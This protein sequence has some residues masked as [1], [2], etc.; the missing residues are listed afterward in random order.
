MRAVLA[1]LRQRSWSRQWPWTGQRSWTTGLACAVLAV[2]APAPATALT[3]GPGLPSATAGINCVFGDVDPGTYDLRGTE[4]PEG[5][6]L[7]TDPVTGPYV[8]TADNAADGVRFDI[9]NQRGE[10]FTCK[11][12][13]GGRGGW[14]GWGDH[15]GKGKSWPPH[16]R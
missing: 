5:Y 14:G 11:G 10:P 3:L 15:G 16:R 9:A 2:S 13:K 7:P 8:I 6:V 4:V 12:D 1:W